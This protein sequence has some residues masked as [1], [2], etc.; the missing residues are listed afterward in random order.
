MAEI[1]WTEPKEPTASSVR[2]GRI[3]FCLVG[4]ILLGFGGWFSYHNPNEQMLLATFI[5]SSGLI[6][7]WLGVALPPKVVAHFGFELPWFIG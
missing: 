6:C 5:L 3:V 1:D 2:S 7:V 4:A